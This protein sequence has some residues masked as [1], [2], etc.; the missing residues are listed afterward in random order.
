MANVKLLAAVCATALVL[1]G[2][3][4]RG[5]Q[6]EPLIFHDLRAMTPTVRSVATFW[7]AVTDRQPVH[8]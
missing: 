1:A 2:T 8:R 5:S 6:V 3:A 7:P 4:T